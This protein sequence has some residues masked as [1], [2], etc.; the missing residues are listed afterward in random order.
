MSSRDGMDATVSAARGRRIKPWLEIDGNP[1]PMWRRRTVRSVRLTMTNDHRTAG[2]AGLTFAVAVIAGFSL[3]PAVD[4]DATADQFAGQLAAGRSSLL[5]SGVAMAIA[6]VALHWFLAS[7]AT[8]LDPDRRSAAAAVL[9]PAGAAAGGLFALGFLSVAALAAWAP[10]GG[11]EAAAMQ[12]AARIGNTATNVALL[13]LAAAAAAVAALR[14]APAWIS[15][16]GLVAG[17]AS[18]IAAGRALDELAFLALLLWLVWAIALAITL[19]RRARTPR[20]AVV[21]SGA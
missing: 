20:S 13:P 4:F 11:A 1:E 14:T 5:A 3:Q 9:A 10:A 19:L 8:V 16:L 17:A 7:L 21:V 15:V 18:V 12:A 2:L 6:A